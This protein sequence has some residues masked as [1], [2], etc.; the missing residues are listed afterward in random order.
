MVMPGCRF[1]GS[2]AGKDSLVTT[3]IFDADQ[4]PGI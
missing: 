3:G 2:G 1:A 4:T